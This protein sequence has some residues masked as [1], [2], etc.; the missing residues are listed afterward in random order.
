MSPRT[1]ALLAIV[2]PVQICPLV[3]QSSQSTLLTLPGQGSYTLECKDEILDV[4]KCSLWCKWHIVPR[5]NLY[6]YADPSY[7]QG[8]SYQQLAQCMQRLWQSRQEIM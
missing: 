2:C 3:C 5:S 7:L 1:M 4:S 6:R 8:C